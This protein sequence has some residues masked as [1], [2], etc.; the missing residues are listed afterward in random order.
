MAMDGSMEDIIEIITGTGLDDLT[1]YP[2]SPAVN[3]SRTE[4][5]E[6]IKRA[7]IM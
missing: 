3:F 2:V 7:D 5:P 1:A 4:G 6:L